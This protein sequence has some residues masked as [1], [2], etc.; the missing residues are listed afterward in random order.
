M[1]IYL[2]SEVENFENCVGFWTK[3]ERDEFLVTDGE[4]FQSC[5]DCDI[6]N[7]ILKVDVVGGVAYEHEEN[8]LPIEIIDFDND[9]EDIGSL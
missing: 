9:K 5:G 1:K 7:P 8:D 4:F 2:A 6:A 3:E